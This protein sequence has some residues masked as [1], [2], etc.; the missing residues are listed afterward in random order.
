[1]LYGVNGKAEHIAVIARLV[2]DPT[3]AGGFRV[4]EIGG[5]TSLGKYNRDGWTVAEKIV[6]SGR[7]LG[8]VSPDPL[9][10]KP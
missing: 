4:L 8:Y 5:N 9:D 1:V 10:G 3:A 7:V 2:P 6:E